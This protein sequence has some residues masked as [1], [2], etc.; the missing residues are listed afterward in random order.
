MPLGSEIIRTGALHGNGACERDRR[1]AARERW[2]DDILHVLHSLA[3][4][5]LQ[6]ESR[7][8]RSSITNHSSK[9]QMRVI[10]LCVSEGVDGNAQFHLA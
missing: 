5:P 9:A 7:G 3:A 6:E 1:R 2:R 4:S 8:N 10:S